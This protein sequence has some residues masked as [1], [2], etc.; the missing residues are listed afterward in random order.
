MTSVLRL[1]GWN[2]HGWT[3]NYRTGKSYHLHHFLQ[4]E[5]PL[6]AIIIESSLSGKEGDKLITPHDD[7]SISYHQ[8]NP[9]LNR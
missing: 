8:P 3:T 7:Y 2:V 1:V 5:Q 4:E 6:C 9:E